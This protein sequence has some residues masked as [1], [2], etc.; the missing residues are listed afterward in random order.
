MLRKIPPSRLDSPAL[1]VIRT[2][3]G[4]RTW[5]AWEEWENE[6]SRIGIG[7]LSAEEKLFSRQ[8][9]AGPDMFNCSPDLAFDPANSAWAAWL[10]FSDDGY[11][12]YVEDLASR[13]RWVLRPN[14]SAEVS[15]PKILFDKSGT[16][17]VF[18]NEAAQ[19]KWRIVY[20]VFDGN[21]WSPKKAVF[22]ETSFP[23]VNPDAVPDE[24]GLIWLAWSGYDGA[25]YEIYLTRWDGNDWSATVPLTENKENDLFPSLCMGPQDLPVV[26][27][28]RSA[29][30]GNQVFAATYQGNGARGETA[31]SPPARELI[32][33]RLTSAAGRAS[34]V[35]RLDDRLAARE[36][37]PELF[38]LRKRTVARSS[39][40][41]PPEEHLIFNPA[42][43][44]AAYIGFG[45]S[46][47]Y[48]YIDRLPAPELGYPPRLSVLLNENFGPTAMIN[49]GLGGETTPEGLVRIDEVLDT[50]DARYILIMEGT[51]DVINPPILMETA[52]F[53]IE[54]MARKSRQAG[55][56]PT[57]TTILPRLDWFGT[58]PF[59]RNRLLALNEL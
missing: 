9:T 34:V 54:E 17:W 4:G 22:A 52:A 26:S 33:P 36:L 6:R 39:A 58:T 31:V 44:E 32:L 23:S 5:A 35:W 41:A 55:L 40:S 14:E 56:F 59:F 15:N 25:D 7:C 30:K 2:D 13:K 38:S 47:T 19:K 27:W 51:N 49:E 11:R 28:M 46:I 3:A 16:A 50:W 57:I 37:T 43:N 12:I 24:Q 29:A 8:M 21:A 20:R 18:W 45:D 1:P 48:G 10:N 42:R 53:N